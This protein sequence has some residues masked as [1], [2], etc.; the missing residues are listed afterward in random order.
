MAHIFSCKSSI[1]PDGLFGC[2]GLKRNST[3]A[4]CGPCSTATTVPI[5]HEICPSRQ[6]MTPRQRLSIPLHWKPVPGHRQRS[7]PPQRKKAHGLT[8]DIPR[9]PPP[10]VSSRTKSFTV[11][12][13][14]P[15]A[16][17]RLCSSIPAM[18][19]H[20]FTHL[21]AAVLLRPPCFFKLAAKL[22]KCSLCVCVAAGSGSRGTCRHS[23]FSRSAIWSRVAKFDMGVKASA[24][25]ETNTATVD[26]ATSMLSVT[27]QFG[28]LLHITRYNL[29]MPVL[30]NSVLHSPILRTL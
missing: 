30:T 16:P 25:L 10:G 3:V 18:E 7:L 23:L 9:L 11:S 20:F 27:T 5:H 1:L 29:Y 12:S 6:T 26:V 21:S 13:K 15:P 28:L 8:H 4:C 24:N 2:H 19:S 22:L 14:S 17:I